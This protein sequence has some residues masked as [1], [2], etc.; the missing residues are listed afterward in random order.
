MGVFALWLSSVTPVGVYSL[1]CIYPI[2]SAGDRT[3][4]LL[5]RRRELGALIVLGAACTREAKSK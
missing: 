5:C 1:R 3:L 4:T 2:G